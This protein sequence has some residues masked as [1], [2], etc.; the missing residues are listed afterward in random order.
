MQAYYSSFVSSSGL[1]LLSEEES[2]HLLKVMRVRAGQVLHVFDGRGNLYEAVLLSSQGKQA[3]I[4]VRRLVEQQTSLSPEFHLVVAVPRH[5]DR[6]EWLLE[7]CTELGVS[8]IYPIITERTEKKNINRE[9]AERILL[10]AAKQ[11][12]H[13]ILPRLMPLSRLEAMDGEGFPCKLVAAIS[14]DAKDVHDALSPGEKTIL[15]IGPEGDFTQAELKILK[16][17]GFQCISLGKS[18]LRLETAAV[19]SCAVFRFVNR[20]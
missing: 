19:Y 7:K 11:S 12:G 17:K 6:W 9:R 10:A 13:W 20:W 4:E 15:L 3:A 18:R 5:P 2:Q 16:E 14:S 8:A 1:C